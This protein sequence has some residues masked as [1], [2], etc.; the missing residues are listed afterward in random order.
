MK[1]WFKRPRF[2]LRTCFILLTIISL[3][4]LAPRYRSMS[5]RYAV[6]Q[7]RANGIEVATATPD[8]SRLS[9]LI[10]GDKQFDHVRKVVIA[11]K[12]SD[13]DVSRMRLL[14]P[15]WEIQIE[16][17]LNSD[18]LL[19]R[20]AEFPEL[21][22]LEIKDSPVSRESFGQICQISTSGTFPYTILH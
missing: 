22:C 2:S 16:G 17:C 4:I 8:Q 10:Y 20:V 12:L 13:A 11:N 3:L 15:V 19:S 21:V 9:W 1:D 5:Q 7:L 6:K 14:F 18:K